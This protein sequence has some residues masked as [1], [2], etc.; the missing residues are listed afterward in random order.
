MVPARSDPLPAPFGPRPASDLLR[1]TL[2][3]GLE[4]QD[5]L[6]ETATCLDELGVEPEVADVRLARLAH[7]QPVQA[8]QD[9]Q[10]SALVAELLGGEQ[11]AAEFGAVRPAHRREATID[12]RCG[13]AALF[14]VMA[15]QLDVRACRCEDLETDR[16]R[17]REEGAK[18]LP[19]R[20]Q[21]SSG[22]AR[23]G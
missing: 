21:R 5:A 3:A 20:L 1:I 16:R 11:E 19:I 6:A 15:E 9:R 18:I 14:H 13:E 2:R 4:R 10:G 12:R 22:V 17:P 8:E 23:K 7:P